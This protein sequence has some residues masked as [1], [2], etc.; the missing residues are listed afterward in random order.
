MAAS[1]RVITKNGLFPGDMEKVWKLWSP[2]VEQKTER[3]ILIVILSWEALLRASEAAE[4]K[5]NDL[6]FENAMIRVGKLFQPN[7]SLT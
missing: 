1:L 6:E 2:K 4:L 5:W 7:V 3:D